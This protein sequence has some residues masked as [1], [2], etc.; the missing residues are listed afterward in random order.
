LDFLFELFAEYD[1]RDAIASNDKVYSYR[2][3]LSEIEKWRDRL[4]NLGVKDHSVVSI[5]ADFSFNSIS[6]FFAL[7]Q[8]KCVL[9]PLSSAI[10]PKL[11]EYLELA[12]TEHLFDLENF[13]PSKSY[14]KREALPKHRL[15]KELRV[16]NES[17]LVV[18]SSGT[19]GKPKCV[20]HKIDLLLNKF[21]IRRHAKR[22]LSFLLF[23]HLGGI[24]TMLYA[25]S[26]GGFCVTIKK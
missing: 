9:V 1:E 7:I 3:L 11:E 16:V 25:L 15:Y 6:L 4:E 19:D 8:K 5:F 23:D 24:N 14:Q 26:N 18:F 10:G 13:E 22:I 12:Q 21:K 2:D 17:G 20:L